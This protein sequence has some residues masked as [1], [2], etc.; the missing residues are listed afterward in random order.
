[1]EKV[2]IVIDMQN[3]FI[4]GNLGSKEAEAIVPAVVKKIREWDGDMIVTLD[5]H[6]ENYMETLE[7]HYLPVPHCIRMTD[8]WEINEEVL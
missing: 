7:G 6:E 2:L 5:T 4:T 8:G 1:M 3:D